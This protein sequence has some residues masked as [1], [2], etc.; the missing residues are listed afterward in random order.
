MVFCLLH[1]CLVSVLLVSVS[2]W[3][4]FCCLFFVHHF[5][6]YFGLVV[7]LPPLG[8]DTTLISF[9]HFTSYFYS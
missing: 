4:V 5:S 3:V 2:F 6:M 7:C 9:F 1:A 8:K